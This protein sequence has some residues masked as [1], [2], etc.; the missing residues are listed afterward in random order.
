MN[1]TISLVLPLALACACGDA[2]RPPSGRSETSLEVV[3]DGEADL[4]FDG[5]LAEGQ[6]ALTFDDGPDPETTRRILATLAKHG[7]LATFFQVGIHVESHPEITR[8]ILAAGH[9]VGSHTWDHPDLTQL[10]LAE[11]I[12][13]VK[14]G[15]AAVERASEARVHDTFFRFPQFA[16]SDELRAAVRDQALVAFHAN[17]V[18][19]D[20]LTPDPNELLA[21]ALAAVD[22]ERHGIVLFHDIQPQTADMLDAFLDE[23]L[24]RGYETVVFRPKPTLASLGAARGIRVGSYLAATDHPAAFPVARREL[25]LYTMPAFIDIVHPAPH[26][27]D[28]GVVDRTV[29][30]AP[31][32]TVM[33]G[34]C[35]VYCDPVTAWIAEGSF[36]GAELEEILV[37]HVTTVVGHYRTKYP[38]RVVAW[39]VVNEPFSFTGDG[40]PWN[41]IGL[42]AGGRELDYVR[43]ALRAARAADPDAKLYVNDFGIEALNAK[44][45]RMLRLVGDLQR[46]GVPIDGVGFQSHFSI[47]EGGPFP[48]PP[49]IEQMVANLNRFS[50]AGLE[51]AVTE[52]DVSIRD[53]DVSPETLAEQAARFQDLATAC[54]SADRCVA[55]ITWGVGDA[56]SWI[57]EFFPG[58]GSALLFDRA[59]RPKPA[60]DAVADALRVR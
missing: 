23:I 37:D 31:V 57:P 18:T 60:Y 52:A 47:G 39:N 24:A 40:C 7:V 3:V 45:D 13:E 2:E 33:L 43:I 44:S 48:S 9:S 54:V 49:P 41:R 32:S 4:P 27:F 6:L 14:R 12:D 42:E 22:A 28:F 29:E 30:L 26:T 36:T 10:P 15:V 38:G 21:K 56:D 35:L 55:F 51:T 46:E 19:E 17:I 58:F 59:F 53:A 50:A 1:R 25:N 11:A 16:S 8:E 20:W 34:H 5:G